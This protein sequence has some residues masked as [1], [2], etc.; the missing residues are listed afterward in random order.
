M[1]YKFDVKE[2]KGISKTIIII[3]VAAVAVLLIAGIIFF[4]ISSNGKQTKNQTQ[5]QAETVWDTNNEITLEEKN[6]LKNDYLGIFSILISDKYQTDDENL[7]ETASQLVKMKGDETSNTNKQNT[8]SSTTLQTENQYSNTLA[9][10]VPNTTG[11]ETQT[12]VNDTIVITGNNPLAPSPT[13]TPSPSPTPSANSS[14]NRVLEDDDV[15]KAIKEIK[16]TTVSDLGVILDRNTKSI[17]PGFVTDIVS[18]SKAN[19]IYNITYKVCWPEQKD[20]IKYGAIDKINT[21]AIDRLESTT[22]NIQLTRNKASEFEYSE[23]NVKSISEVEKESPVAYYLSYT[24]NK[25]GVIDQNGNIIINNIYDWITI[26][27]NYKDIFICQLNSATAT[28]TTNTS[29]TSDVTNTATTTT[30]ATSTTPKITVLNKLGEEIFEDYSNISVIQS[31]FTNWWYEKDFLVYELNGKYGAIDYDGFEVFEPVYDKI[32][33]LLYIEGKLILTQNNKQALADITGKIRSNSYKYS[34]VGVLG[35]QI[36]AESLVTGQRT[37]DDVAKMM[38]EGLNI[39]GQDT[40]G[41]TE[42]IEVV[43]EEQYKPD[44]TNI[45]QLPTPSTI[46]TW[47]YFTDNGYIIYFK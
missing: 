33:P 10:D 25:Y 1:H 23:Y 32:E 17:V 30:T 28:T 44:T 7:V 19:G 8:S 43:T 42:V 40:A 47:Q 13:P 27:N 5:Q 12:M 45:P 36:P 37:L 29:T 38:Q 35:G 31:A 16:G 4:M 6:K 2:N 24:N 39:V 26:P 46:G 21:A 20:I 14:Q 15:A 22:V 18:I 3:I 11:E 41:V 34:K 9:T